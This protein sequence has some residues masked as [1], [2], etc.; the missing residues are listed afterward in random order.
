MD[1]LSLVQYHVALAPT[2]LV[3]AYFLIFALNWPRHRT[4]TRA[5]TCIVVVV[6]AMRYLIWRF[7]ATVQPMTV[8]DGFA[9]YWV[10]FL[11]L[12]E[13]LAF[14]EL[15]LFLVA[16][17]RYAD[18]SAEAD[19]LEAGFFTRPEA[20]LP[21][22]DVFIPTYNEPL[23]GILTRVQRL[24]T[25]GRNLR[26]LQGCRFLKVLPDC[27]FSD[28]CRLGYPFYEMILLDARFQRRDVGQ[29]PLAYRT[30]A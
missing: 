17:S 2:F 21:T 28:P 13:V 15:A 30:D 25:G 29:E 8:D 7:T 10:W 12:V 14:S 5:I 16:M 18:R 23:D 26:A 1:Q 20:D 22:V 3:G 11:F 19:R 6:V 9:F 27:F 24:F 4:W